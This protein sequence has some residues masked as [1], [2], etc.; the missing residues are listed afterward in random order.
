[1]ISSSNE[2]ATARLAEALALLL[3][4]VR[5]APPR[6]HSIRRVT[7]HLWE[8]VEVDG[9]RLGL[10]T[11][12]RNFL[13]GLAMRRGTRQPKDEPVDAGAG[14]RVTAR[15][16]RRRL[17]RRLGAE[18][19]G[20]LVPVERDEPYRFREPEEV[21]ATCAASPRCHPPTELRVVGRAGART[22]GM[23]SLDHFA[24]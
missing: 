6:S 2:R 10:G 8:A 21:A 4:S 12:E 5:E 16:C 9:A 15:E 22:V 1:M 18:L 13:F 3:D 11:A 14:R 24:G 20:L 17:G 23:G 19:A 7:I